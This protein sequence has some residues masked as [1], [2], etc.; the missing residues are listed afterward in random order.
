MKLDS[1]KNDMNDFREKQDA[2]LKLVAAIHVKLDLVGNGKNLRKIP[3]AQESRNV[4]NVNIPV[5]LPLLTEDSLTELLST[6]RN[7]IDVEDALVNYIIESK[8]E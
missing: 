7:N 6:L 1:V 3:T 2:L 4:T 5:N 8:K